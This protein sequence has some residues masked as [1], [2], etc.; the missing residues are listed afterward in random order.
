[1]CAFQ[2]VSALLLGYCNGGMLHRRSQ[3]TWLCEPFPKDI[4]LSGEFHSVVAAIY[5]KYQITKEIAK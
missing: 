2:I 4:T 3:L 1:V 5:V